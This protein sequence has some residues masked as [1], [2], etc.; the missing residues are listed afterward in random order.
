MAIKEKAT[1]SLDAQTKRDGIAILDAMGLSLSTFAEMSLRQLVCDGRLPFTPSV[2]PSF[3]KD[4]EGYPL[5]KANMDDPR[6]VT[7]QIRDGA[8]ILPEDWDDD[9]D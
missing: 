2:R 1:I 4:N 9:E 8:V 7:P 6:I 5:F 3:E